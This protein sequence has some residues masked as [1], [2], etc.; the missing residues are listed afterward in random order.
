MKLY[1]FLIVLFF[2]K[3]SSVV[4]WLVHFVSSCAEYASTLNEFQPS[5]YLFLE[6]LIVVVVVCYIFVRFFPFFSLLV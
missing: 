1:I 6:L 2:Y 5:E 3:V 4:F